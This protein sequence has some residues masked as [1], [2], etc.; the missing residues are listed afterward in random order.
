LTSNRTKKKPDSVGQFQLKSID[1]S[2][3]VQEK[4]KSIPKQPGVY[5]YRDKHQRVIYVGKAKVLANRVKSYFQYSAD[6][7]PKLKIL[8]R[9]IHDVEFFITDTEKEALILENNLIKKYQPR[10]NVRL[11]DDKTYPHIR[12]TKEAFPQVYMTRQVVKDGSKYFGPYTNVFD[13]KNALTTL[14]KFFMVRTCNFPLSKETIEK[15][16]YRV[17]LDYHIKRCAGPCEGFQSETD[18]QHIIKNVERFLNGKA[19]ELRHDLEEQMHTAAKNL[20]FEEAAKL[21]D[22]IEAVGVF[23]DKKQKV[24]KIETLAQDFMGMVTDDK[25]VCI[26]ILKVREGKVIAKQEFM[27]VNEFFDEDEV[28]FENFLHRFY[29]EQIQIADE[30][31]IPESHSTNVETHQA[32]IREATSSSLKLIQPKIGDKVKLIKMARLNAQQKLNEIRL[33]RLKKDFVPQGLK[34]LQ[35]DLHLKQPPKRIECF[36]N[37]N[38]QGTDAVSSMVVFVNGRPVKSEYRKFKTKSLKDGVADDFA[39]MYEVITRRYKRLRD[40]KKPFP[41]LIMVDG[42]KGQLSSAVQAL[43]DLGVFPHP[44]IGL[45]KRLEDVFIPDSPDPQNIPKTSSA[46][47]IL[48]QL[49]DESH[50]FAITFHR[51][52]RKKRTLT[53]ELDDI[54]GVGAVR[55]KQLLKHFGSVKK[56]KDATLDELK[57][58]PRLPETLAE[59]IY[60]ALRDS[61]E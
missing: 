26:C 60:S 11:K 42:G 28:I 16:K 38:M 30:L 33:Q 10:F 35:R 17:C 37:S 18:Y 19:S 9:T 48:Q 22:T 47:K 31:Y 59:K 53:S 32:F 24:E 49:R 34:S 51:E 50:R 57:H 20:Q 21:R 40:E 52:R 2:K 7:P 55:R 8:Q 43:K 46:L 25:D 54:A 14:Q 3:P 23:Y 58:V 5:I 45:A 39:T 36:D 41:D 15:K 12:I 4:L 6:R 27:L 29:T 56:I 1:I 61:H 13:V 44:I